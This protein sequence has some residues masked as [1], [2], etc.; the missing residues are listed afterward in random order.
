MNMEELIIKVAHARKNFIL[1]CSELSDE[2]ASFKPSPDSWSVAEIA[3]HM[4]WAEQGAI[5]GMW[6]T[7]EAIKNNKPIWTGQAIHQGLS[8]EQIIEK[9]WQ[10]K[11]NVPETARPRWGGSLKYWICSLAACQNLLQALCAVID[12]VDPEQVIYPHVISGPLN[13]VQRMEFLRFHLERHQKQIE[14]IKGH[15]DFPGHK[16]II[17]QSPPANIN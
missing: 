7:I 8:I 14:N 15:P 17:V 16:A 6:K 4:V 2:Q 13:A 10:T 9:T 3:E 5:N 1:A 12:G 11:E